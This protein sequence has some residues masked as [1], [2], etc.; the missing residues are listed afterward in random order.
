MQANQLPQLLLT[1]KRTTEQRFAELLAIT[2][3][4]Q[5]N[6]A[7]SK[8]LSV[9]KARTQEGMTLLLYAISQGIKEVEKI[10]ILIDLGS[11]LNAKDPR[12]KTAIHLAMQYT[13]STEGVHLYIKDSFDGDMSDQRFSNSFILNRGTQ[14]LFYIDSNH[15]AKQLQISNFQQFEN[16]LNGMIT[17]KTST[18]EIPTTSTHY[19][20]TNDQ[21]DTLVTANTGF[22]PNILK[23]LILSANEKKFDFNQTS[24]S[25]ATP[26]QYAALSSEQPYYGGGFSIISSNDAD[27]KIPLFLQ[28]AKGNIDVNKQDKYSTTPLLRCVEANQLVAVVALIRYGADPYIKNTIRSNE[29]NKNVKWDIFAYI[30][31]QQDKNK[32]QGFSDDDGLTMLKERIILERFIYL[33]K[34]ALH[35]YKNDRHQIW[36]KDPNAQRSTLVAEIGK[37][38]TDIEAKM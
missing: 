13:E 11:D 20:L 10:K 25:G 34:Q 2:D 37:T 9:V 4:N 26:L 23:Y 1:T 6:E 16:A 32:A 3:N 24:K 8:D 30:E 21:I 14:K 7:L 36:R 12:G 15:V 18:T 35:K 38:I 33:T 29:N 28:I 5:F 31:H 22:S 27:N 19:F 17:E